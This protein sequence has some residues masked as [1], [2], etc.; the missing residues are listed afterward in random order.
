MTKYTLDPIPAQLERDLAAFAKH[1]VAPLDLTRHGGS[2][3]DT[4]SC[5]DKS[6]VL[7]FLGYLQ[8]QKGVQVK[9]V[10]HVFASASLALAAQQFAK[11]LVDE[12]GLKYDTVGGYLLSIASVARFAHEAV[13]KTGGQAASRLDSSVLAALDSL[14][15]Q[16]RAQARKQDAFDIDTP[17]NWLSWSE[18][19]AARV[20]AETEC[21]QAG[22]A[23]TLDM[24]HDVCLLTVLTFQPPDRV[25]LM[26]TLQLGGSLKR[27]GSGGFLLDV[28]SSTS[29][30]TAAYFGATRTTLPVAICEKITAY[31]E[32]TLFQQGDFLFY[33]GADASQPLSPS[34]WTRL[35][36]NLFRSHS[37]RAVPLAPK[38]LRASFITFLKSGEHSDA[39][40]KAAAKAM[41]HSS[42]TQ[43]S[44]AYHKGKHDEVV[45]AAMRVAVEFASRFSVGAGSSSSTA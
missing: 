27:T 19:Q 13:K 37:A 17:V 40:L 45:A 12:R 25:G 8:E 28:S 33:A 24:L 35:V 20:H 18:V 31:V 5:K 4:T 3:V 30:K 34:A 21:L 1:R 36:K 32:D 9:G 42:K 15:R 6:N 16:C 22:S 7:R 29:H 10:V 39:T 11:H 26:R 43:A 41:R 23:A 44:S 2:C 14:H 38:E